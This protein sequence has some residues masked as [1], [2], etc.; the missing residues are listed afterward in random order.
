MPQAQPAPAGL[1]ELVALLLGGLIALIIIAYSIRVVREYERAVVFRLGRVVGVKGPGLIIVVPF[2]DRVTVI[3]L[4]IHTVDVPRQRIITKDNVE[5]SVDAVVYYRV[6]DPLKA[7]LTVRNYNVAVT[8]LSQT[9]LRDVIGKSELDDLLSRR[10]EL[11][12]EL[13]RIL[14]ELTD[15]WGI[16]VTAVTLKEVVLPEGMVR[17]MARQAE[18]ERWRRAKII[19]A[20]GERQA[21]KIL[22][23]AA[24]T[25]ERHPA[26]LR[27]RELQALIEVAKEKN[28]VVFYPITLGAEAASLAALGLEAGRRARERREEG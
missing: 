4:R 8:L 10:E 19:E 24:Q 9:V 25:Y 11:N 13:Q 1:G 6:Q 14:D 17:A 15:P 18:A 26:A 28:T 20:E 21:A 22:E 7:V 3:D 27:L 16:K 23:E 5:V 12:K 2:I